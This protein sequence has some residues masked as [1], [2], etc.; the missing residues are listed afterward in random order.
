MSILFTHKTRL[1]GLYNVDNVRHPLSSDLFIKVVTKQSSRSDK[2]K[3]YIVNKDAKWFLL[4]KL[5]NLWLHVFIYYQTSPA[6][7]DH[8]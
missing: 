8:H 2:D 6:A 7:G 4:A 5:V 3:C 1:N